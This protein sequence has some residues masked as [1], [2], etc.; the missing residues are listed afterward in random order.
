M[1]IDGG[2]CNI[3]AHRYF[4][5]PTAN[6]HMGKMIKIS[7]PLLLSSQCSQTCGT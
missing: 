6:K 5:M 7:F 3:I 1:I 4:I 2:I